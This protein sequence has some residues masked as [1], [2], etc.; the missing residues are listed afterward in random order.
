MNC[1]KLL[2]HPFI[3]GKVPLLRD[4]NAKNGIGE[5]G[6]PR[7]H[8]K[9]LTAIPEREETPD[10]KLPDAIVEE[11]AEG[12]QILSLTKLENQMVISI[13]ESEEKE[14]VNVN[15]Q[16]YSQDDNKSKSFLKKVISEP[17]PPPLP[18]ILIIISFFFLSF[19]NPYPYPIFNSIFHPKKFEKNNF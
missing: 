5:N 13:V 15:F 1:F 16:R 18:P 7:K 10:H 6:E 3:T 8:K 14:K 2:R 17:P 12:K 4:P 11:E 19:L 9:I